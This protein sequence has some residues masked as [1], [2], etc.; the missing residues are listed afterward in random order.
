MIKVILLGTLLAV[1]C[2]G[3]VSYSTSKSVHSLTATETAV[4]ANIRGGE[5]L[6]IPQSLTAFVSGTTTDGNPFTVDLIRQGNVVNALLTYTTTSA[7]GSTDSPNPNGQIPPGFRPQGAS[8]QEFRRDGNGNWFS[9]SI[10][11]DGDIFLS[12]FDGSDVGATASMQSGGTVFEIN[13]SYV[14]KKD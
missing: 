5:S 14:A 9:P 3:T 7:P 8:I 13:F 6:S 2:A 4:T 10:Q 1:F 11:D 12:G